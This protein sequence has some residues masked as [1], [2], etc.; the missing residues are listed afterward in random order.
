MAI[1]Y[2][3]TNLIAKN[4]ET[5]ARFYCEVFACEIVEP[6]RD[7]SGEWLERGTGVHGARIRGAHLR[8]PGYGTDGPTL[9]VFQYDSIEDAPRPVP[10]RAGF[11]HIA[12]A[13]DDVEAAVLAVERGGG[14]RFSEVVA[15]PVRGAGTVTFTYVRDPEG[16]LVELQSW[17]PQA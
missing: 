4:W 5:L 1:R 7:L 11:G 15:L 6:R 10:N 2:G 12:F 16:N 8:L 9:E 17:T 13:V 14:E 3:H